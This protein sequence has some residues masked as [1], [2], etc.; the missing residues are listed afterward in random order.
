[1]PTVEA[2]E[3]RAL[4]TGPPHAMQHAQGLPATRW[5]CAGERTPLH[6]LRLLAAVAEIRSTATCTLL[7]LPKSQQDSSAPGGGEG[8]NHRLPEDITEEMSLQPSH[9]PDVAA[10]V[11]ACVRLLAKANGAEVRVLRDPQVY[12]AVQG[13]LLRLL[14]MEEENQEMIESERGE[15]SLT[16][17]QQSVGQQQRQLTRA[18]KRLLVRFEQEGFHP[19]LGG[20]SFS[21]VLGREEKLQCLASLKRE[22][23]S[24]LD[25]MRIAL[26]SSDGSVEVELDEREMQADPLMAELVRQQRAAAANL[27]ANQQQLG[28]G[29]LLRLDLH[30]AHLLLALRPDRAI[31]RQTYAAAVKGR[32]LNALECMDALAGVRRWDCMTSRLRSSGED[33]L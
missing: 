8:S 22:E 16:L 20:D 33:E 5:P 23:R 25:A 3:T 6:V 31:S 17:Q 7:L 12:S 18:I 4:E 26:V 28:A 14:L 15:E 32:C 30:A 24:L 2:M 11:R 13:E 19:Q 1:M 21:V 9:D 27:T 29:G 10:A